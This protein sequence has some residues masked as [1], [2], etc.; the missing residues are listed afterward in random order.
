MTKGI[1][2]RRAYYSGWFKLI[3][4]WKNVKFESGKSSD[5][6]NGLALS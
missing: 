4:L 6:L 5:S 3:V 2:M 1:R